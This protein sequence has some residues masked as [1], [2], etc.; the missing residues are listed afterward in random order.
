ME[1]PQNLLS[2]IKNIF[3]T[4]SY[5]SSM[6]ELVY[7]TIISFK[8]CLYNYQRYVLYIHNE[9]ACLFMQ[10]TPL[11]PKVSRFP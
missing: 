11:H 1:F 6:Q 8:K 9:S 2:F 5:K 10:Q 3:I 4:F 7:E